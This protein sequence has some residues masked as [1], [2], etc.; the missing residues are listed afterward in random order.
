MSLPTYRKLGLGEVK[1]TTVSL[2][3]PIE[4]S[5]MQEARL[6]ITHQSKKFDIPDEFHCSWHRRRLRNSNNLGLTLLSNRLNLGWH[7][8]MWANFESGG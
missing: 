7:G 4:T 6:S 8:E 1:E 2:Q 5:N 3:L